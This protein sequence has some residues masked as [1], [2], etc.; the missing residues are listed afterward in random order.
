MLGCASTITSF[1]PE[2]LVQLIPNTI[3]T[4]TITYTNL[5]IINVTNE[6]W[7]VFSS[8]FVNHCIATY[9]AIAMVYDNSF[10]YNPPSFS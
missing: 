2:L 5:L 7:K 3:A 8:C 4:H 9:I 10:E 1:P 6:L